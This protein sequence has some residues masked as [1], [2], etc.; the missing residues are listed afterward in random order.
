MTCHSQ[1][2]AVGSVALR[3]SQQEMQ[4]ADMWA[5]LIV[6]AARDY[7]ILATRQMPSLDLFL[8]KI[9]RIVCSTKS[10]SW[11][12]CCDSPSLVGSVLAHL[13]KPLLQHI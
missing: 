7:E 4:S 3:E 6:A 1:P 11:T 5:P 10:V 9:D 13:E 12:R 2:D 8:E